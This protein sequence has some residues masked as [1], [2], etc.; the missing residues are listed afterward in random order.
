MF[1][2]SISLYIFLLTLSGTVIEANLWCYRRRRSCSPINCQVNSWSQW[3]QCTAQ[4]CGVSGIRR[5]I[6]NIIR[7]SSCGGSGCPS[8]QETITCYGST[9]VNCTYS[10]WSSWSAC[11]QCGESQTRRRY[12]VTLGQCGGTPCLG[13]PALSQTRL[14]KTRCLNEGNLENVDLCTCP[15]KLFKSCC[16]YNGKLVFMLKYGQEMRNWH[17]FGLRK[18]GA[19][20]PNWAV[21]FTIV[22]ALLRGSR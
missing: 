16:L 20:F 17:H 1:S 2:K 5:R 11:S 7:Y 6:R 3:S 9:P 14:C 21:T 22:C 4:P 8:L 13:G 12:A 19:C 18:L 10:A 15:P